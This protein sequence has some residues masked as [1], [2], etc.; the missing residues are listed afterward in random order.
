MKFVRIFTLFV[1]TAFLAGCL[2]ES[3]V[4]KVIQDNPEIV[5][6]AIKKNPEKFMEVVQEAAYKA[7]MA[8]RQKQDADESKAMEEEFKTPKVPVIGED[9]A[10]IGKADAPITVVEYSDFQCPFCSK[11]YL[12]VRELKEKYGDKLRFI[13][14][15]LPLEDKHP[16]AMPAAKYFEAIALQSKEKAYKF[17]DLLF[18][19]QSGLNKDGGKFLDDLTKKVGADLGKVKKDLNSEKVSKNIKDDMDE[20]RKFGFNGTP[21]FLVNGVSVHGAYPLPH[22]DKIIERQLA[23]K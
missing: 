2:G 1:M 15:H 3:Q 21:G 19:N 14:K 7:Q 11:G 5:F 12:V 23:K 17:H 4:K 9:R 18:E 10:T 22:F 8:A 20:A 16:E 13:Y 6:E